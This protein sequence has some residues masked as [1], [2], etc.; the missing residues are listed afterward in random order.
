[1]YVTREGWMSIARSARVPLRLRFLPSRSRQSVHVPEGGIEERKD[2]R[3]GR[4]DTRVG[5]TEDDEAVSIFY[6]E[7][8][9]AKCLNGLVLQVVLR[10]AS[11]EVFK[12]QLRT[13]PQH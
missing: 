10:R 9:L 13:R 7:A 4:D 6:E 12:Y 3:P 8:R 5:A 2:W 1:M 11:M